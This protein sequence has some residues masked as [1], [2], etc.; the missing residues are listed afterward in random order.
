[1]PA[2]AEL[3]AGWS[4]PLLLLGLLASLRLLYSAVSALHQAMAAFVLPH[5]VGRPDYAASYGR[6]ALVTGC[7]GGIGRAYALALA[8]RGLGLVLVSRSEEKLRALEEEVR[9]RFG[10]ETLVVAADFTGD[11]AVVAEV[12]RA[13]EEAGVEVG[14]LIN[15]VGVS[16]GVRPF[17]EVSRQM[18]I[19]MIRVNVTAATLLCHALVPGMAARGRGAVVNVGSMA[20]IIK[21]PY[22]AVYSATKHYIHAFTEALHAEYGPTGVTVQEVNPNL[23]E[24]AMT[25]SFKEFAGS[26][27]MPDPATFAW[28]SLATLGW[29]RQTCGYWCHALTLPLY[30]AQVGGTACTK[31]L[32]WLVAVHCAGP[33]KAPY[34]SPLHGVICAFTLNNRSRHT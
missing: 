18:V 14:I 29:R 12:V 32:G 33:L 1:M 17:C 7:T 22:V 28:W 34:M 25:A 16:A 19:N 8:E 26:Y 10:V 15:N 20:G 13:V 24:T 5:L 6:W 2:L 4:G 11:E 23:V 31:H 30:T 27:M 9:E 21:G 3:L